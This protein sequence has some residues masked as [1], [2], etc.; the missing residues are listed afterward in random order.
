MLK[1]KLGAATT[2]VYPILVPK[3]NPAAVAVYLVLRQCRAKRVERY[4]RVRK[5]RIESAGARGR[6]RTGR[7]HPRREMETEELYLV[8]WT[9]G[10]EPSEQKS[11]H[12]HERLGRK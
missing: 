1:S 4:E 11:N 7:L 6:R 8:W 2:E 9:K 10:T 5:D 12:V 3:L